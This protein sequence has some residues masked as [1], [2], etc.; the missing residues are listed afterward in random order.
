MG[1]TPSKVQES[2]STKAR[3]GGAQRNYSEYSSDM[4]RQ[5]AALSTL[6]PD[7]VVPIERRFGE[8]TRDISYLPPMG[9]VRPDVVALPGSSSQ[10]PSTLI[11]SRA[12]EALAVKSGRYDRYSSP[13]FA[14]AQAAPSIEIIPSPA[15]DVTA[16]STVPLGADPEAAAPN[17]EAA[18]EVSNAVIVALD[19]EGLVQ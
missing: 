6:N 3:F 15:S 16:L 11:P 1:H 12:L 8:Y 2:Y 19:R 17:L 18:P 7:I 10:L 5:M 13:E 14:M 4:A 9:D